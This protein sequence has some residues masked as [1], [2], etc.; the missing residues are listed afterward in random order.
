VTDA[1]WAVLQP[2]LSRPASPQGGRP[3]K[4]GLRAI[5]DAIRYVVRS[6]CAWR[7]LPADLPS[8]SA[9]YWWFAKWTHD[10]TLARLRDL[11]RD[12][13]R[14]SAGR[15]ATPSA[16]TI[17][18]QSVRAADTVPRSSRGWDAGKQINGRKR[19]LAVDTIGLLLV[20]LVTAANSRTAT[21]P[22][23]CCGACALA[24]AASACAGRTPGTQA[25]WWSGHARCCA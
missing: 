17:D 1:E 22:E 24:S 8:W 21:P 3:P 2:L 16:A 23:P 12:Q 25:S 9:V 20:V 5:V 15:A 19:H 13:V 6:G 4:H 10:G 18:S 14:T 7:L 11:L